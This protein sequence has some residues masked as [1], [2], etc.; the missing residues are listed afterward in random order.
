MCLPA[1][2]FVIE[3]AEVVERPHVVGDACLRER[4][5]ERLCVPGHVE[6]RALGGGTEDAFVVPRVGGT[7]AVLEKLGGDALAERDRSFPGPRN[8][9]SRSSPARSPVSASVSPFASRA[10]RSSV[11]VGSLVVAL[12]WFLVSEAVVSGLCRT[13]KLAP[14]A[15]VRRQADISFVLMNHLAG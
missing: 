1:A 9:V 6:G 12:I 3:V 15:R 4:E 7:G 14:T 10:A 5:P 13:P 8:T 11:P 2:A